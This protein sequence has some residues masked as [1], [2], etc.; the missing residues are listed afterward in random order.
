MSG[1][2]YRMTPHQTLTVRRSDAEVLEVEA[3]W[4]GGGS[5]PPAHFHPAQDEHFELVEGRLRVLIGGAER[6]L[7]PGDVLDIPRGTVHAMTA[8]DGGA[9][10]VWQTRPALHTERF[11]A[12]MDAAQ[13]RGGSLLDVIPAAR[14]HAAEIRFTKPPAWLQGP[15]FAVLGLIGRLR[16]R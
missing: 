9:R 14:A 13:S 6:L 11:F 4:T 5:M 3:T 8:T 15:L 10:A 7:S 1:A 12:A 2:T 16:R